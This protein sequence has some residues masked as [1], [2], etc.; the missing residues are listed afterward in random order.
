MA[1]RDY[2]D[3]QYVVLDRIQN[4]VIADAHAVPGAAP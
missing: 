1:E 4:P 2:D 3:E